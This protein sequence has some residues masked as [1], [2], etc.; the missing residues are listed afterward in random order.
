MHGQPVIKIYNAKQARLI[1]INVLYVN[2]QEFCA[3]NWRS[4]K[5]IL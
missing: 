1:Y 2:K 5:V 4:T 3:S